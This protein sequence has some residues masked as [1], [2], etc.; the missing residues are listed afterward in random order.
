TVGARRVVPATIRVVDIA[1]LVRGAHRGEGL[2]NQ[3]LAHIRETSALLHVVRAFE[4]PEAPHVEGAPDPMRDIGIV[5]LELALA[6][7]ATVERRR[8]RLAPRA[9]TGD[10]AA[11]A[12]LE[13]LEQ[14]E[15]QLNRAEPVRLL[16]AAVREVVRPL[17]LLTDK[18]VAYVLNVGENGRVP[19]LAAVRA[20]A[21]RTGSQV[22]VVNL[23]LETELL[24]LSPEE[25]A[26]YRQALGLGEDALHQV[27]RA[28]YEL[29]GLVTFFSIESGEV[30]AWPVPRG[31]PAQEAAG[32]IHTDMM[33]GFVAAEVIWWE[34]LV[35][36][37]S[38]TAARERG[39]LRTEGRGYVVR[40]GDVITFRFSPR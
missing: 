23:K 32:E 29:L 39:K 20:H 4:D 19:G 9:R 28:A 2:G 26:T 11:R 27:I 21:A 24:E 33:Q 8:E 30:R 18:P 3:F 5:E 16:P 38:V 17:R 34:D 12:E 22:V 37:G 6:D 10:R 40:D 15:A 31:T 14:V 1:G 36:A 25:A 7:L 35:Q 13:V